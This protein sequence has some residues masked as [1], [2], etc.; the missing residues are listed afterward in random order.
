MRSQMKSPKRQQNEDVR[1]L[2]YTAILLAAFIGFIMWA[3]WLT[4]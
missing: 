4:D 3:P 2:I 1:N